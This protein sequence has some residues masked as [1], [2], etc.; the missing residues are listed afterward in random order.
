M[1]ALANCTQLTNLEIST[2]AL[3]PGWS[4]AI[5]DIRSL[6]QFAVGDFGESNVQFREIKALAE[7]PHLRQVRL[8]FYD[9]TYAQYPL[10]PLEES[11][12]GCTWRIKVDNLTPEMLEPLAANRDLDTLVVVCHTLTKDALLALNKSTSLRRL[13]V[14]I[15]DF[16]PEP[17][18]NP[19]FGMLLKGCHNLELLEICLNAEDP[20]VTDNDQLLNHGL[21][22]LAHLPLLTNLILHGRLSAKDWEGVAR[23]KNLR[24]LRCRGWYLGAAGSRQVAHLK[25]LS[26]LEEL[27]LPF[28]E[29]DDNDLDVILSMPKL[30][31]L[32]F[33]TWV[34][35][36]PKLRLLAD[37]PDFPAALKEQIP[38]ALR[39]FEKE[40]QSADFHEHTTTVSIG[41]RK[42]LPSEWAPNPGID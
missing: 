16:P 6:K 40:A 32:E 36:L 35:I 28:Q 4:D 14:Y 23:L 26:D 5:Q 33:D 18:N 42:K 41:W 25:S 24:G 30:H 37:S 15:Y 11:P 27:E 13:Q 20:P 22:H 21:E 19:D 8:G 31:W 1:S 7:N 38:A 39:E 10:S 9:S 34:T 17:K 12:T 29:V 2:A 3:A